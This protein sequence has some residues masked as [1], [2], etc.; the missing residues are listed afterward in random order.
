MKDL[1]AFL[2]FI[3]LVLLAIALGKALAGA[4]GPERLGPLYP[5]FSGG[6]SPEHP[7]VSM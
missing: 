5:I 1:G 7:P 4:V 2:L 3:L 6:Q